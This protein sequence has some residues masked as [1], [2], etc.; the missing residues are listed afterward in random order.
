MKCRRRGRCLLEDRGSPKGRRGKAG[1]LNTCSSYRRAGAGRG[2]P[3]EESVSRPR[4]RRRRPQPADFGLRQPSRP[5]PRGR[6][7]PGRRSSSRPPCRPSSIQTWR[8]GRGS[9][10][11]HCPTTT[12]RRPANRAEPRRPCCEAPT[13]RH[14]RRKRPAHHHRRSGRGCPQWRRRN[15]AGCAA[16]SNRRTAAAPL[17]RPGRSRR[18]AWRCSRTT[19]AWSSSCRASR[20]SCPT[21]P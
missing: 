6:P 17:R 7:R 13:C 2:N 4:T 20:Q 12:P 3:T 19:R 18:F 21:S 15:A 1:R 11:R 10:P 14:P 8:C 5:G 9:R 16:T